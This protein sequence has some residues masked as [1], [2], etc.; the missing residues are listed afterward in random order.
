[1]DHLALQVG[2]V[3]DVQELKR[4]FEE[5]GREPFGGKG[6]GIG[7]AKITLR[8]PDDIQLDLFGGPVDPALAA[9]RRERFGRWRDLFSVLHEPLQLD[10]IE[11][12]AFPS[13]T[14][15]RGERPREGRR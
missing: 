15:I 13:G 3:E 14:A 7:A 11:A 6:L 9:G 2:G 1:M 12:R 4:R 8:D 5:V 10:M